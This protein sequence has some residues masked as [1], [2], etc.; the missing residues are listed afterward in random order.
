MKVKNN[1]KDN[2]CSQA[3]A[4]TKTSHIQNKLNNRISSNLNNFKCV[5]LQSL[6]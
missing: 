1:R 5:Q 2:V 3:K 6:L 4:Q